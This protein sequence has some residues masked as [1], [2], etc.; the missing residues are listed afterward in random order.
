[1]IV[2]ERVPV[3]D[4]FAP[5]LQMQKHVMKCVNQ[6][7]KYQAGWAGSAGPAL[8]ARDTHLRTKETNLG[9]MMADLVRTE[10]DADVALLHAGMLKANVEIPHGPFTWQAVDGLLPES[11]LCYQIKIKG[12]LLL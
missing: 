9:N 6:Y 2:S 4:R 3:D 11:E 5:E 1:M 10:F 7:Q 12:N 8:E